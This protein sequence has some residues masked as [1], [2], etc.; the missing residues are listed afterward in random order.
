MTRIASIVIVA[1]VAI[2]MS[3]ATP[4][5]AAENSTIV[6][7]ALTDMSSSAGMGPMGQMMMGGPGYG[8]GQGMMGRGMMRP[9]YG[10]GPG[11]TGPG[12]GMMG[13]NM[14]M[15][16]MAIRVDQDTIKAGPVKFDVTNWSRYLP[17]EMLVVAVDNPA[18]ALPYDYGEAKVNEDQV[19][20]LGDTSELQ[21]NKSASVEVTL[22]PGSYLLICNVPGHYAAGMAVPLVVKP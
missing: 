10:W 6:K 12:Y 18:T 16:M 14:M 2:A 9:G 22:A 3:T 4:S 7:V 8:W 15:G 11:T 19:K 20:V 1:I 21:P 17:H 5:I 13:P